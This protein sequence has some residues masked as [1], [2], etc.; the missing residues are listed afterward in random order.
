MP[1]SRKGVPRPPPL[2]GPDDDDHDDETDV[3]DLGDWGYDPEEDAAGPGAPP[4]LPVEAEPSTPPSASL[5]ALGPPPD[6]TL[7]AEK[8]AHSI[9]M[10]Q[11][12]E[13][14]MSNMQDSQRRREVRTILRDAKGHVTD[15]ARYDYMRMVQADREE[16]EAHK[17]GR[18]AAAAEPVGPPPA[19]AKIIPLVPRDD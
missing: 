18:A 12:Y 10:R 13:C 6:D 14:M 11:A 8:W 7:A 17:R 4:P 5:Q 9:L 19:G 15:A 16:M 3:D 2:A 1:R